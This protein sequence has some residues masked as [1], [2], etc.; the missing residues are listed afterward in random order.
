MPL[1]LEIALGVLGAIVA[2]YLFWFVVIV[3]ALGV[4]VSQERKD[5]RAELRRPLGHR[6]NK[7]R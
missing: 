3:L 2:I 5:I 6:G 4:M 7:L 1:W